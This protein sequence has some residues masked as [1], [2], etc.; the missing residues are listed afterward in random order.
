MSVP[1][2]DAAQPS[3][4]TRSGVLD[5]AMRRQGHRADALLELLH[6]AQR[7]D[8]HLTRE[9][10]RQLA[11]GLRLPL[12]HV[13]GVATFYNLFR[14]EPPAAHTCT[15]CLGTACYVRGAGEIM[16]GL[17]A[18]GATAGPP[19]RL[20]VVVARC[21][22]ACGAA[23]VVGFDGELR[24]RQSRASVLTALQAWTGP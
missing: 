11:Q 12:A 8:G 9:A 13:Y 1:G 18:R 14:L 15:V 6:L 23:P 22:G 4:E 17:E 5:D 21:I 24:G 7:I 2:G 20:D 3:G 16:A 19:G 10:L